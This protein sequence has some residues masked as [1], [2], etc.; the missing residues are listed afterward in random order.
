MNS[1]YIKLKSRE[2]KPC[3][4]AQVHTHCEGYATGRKVFRWNYPVRKSPLEGIPLEGIPLEGIPL[5]GIPL[6]GIPLQ[7]IPLEGV[8]LEVV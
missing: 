8:P 2:L 7:G 5:E 3:E 4:Q 1:S 6:E